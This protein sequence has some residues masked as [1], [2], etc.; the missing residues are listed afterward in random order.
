MPR[1]VLRKRLVARVR[2]LTVTEKVMSM[3]LS[4]LS[5]GE[6]RGG[7]NCIVEMDETLSNILESSVR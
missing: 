2:A 6:G 7:S 4:I 3:V 5:V 1:M